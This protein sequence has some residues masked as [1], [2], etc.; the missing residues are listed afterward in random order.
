M[1]VEHCENAMRRDATGAPCGVGNRNAR[2][3]ARQRAAYPA[4]P[5]G[6]PLGVLLATDR[7]AVEGRWGRGAGRRPGTLSLPRGAGRGAARRYSS[8]S[9]RPPADGPSRPSRPPPGGAAALVARAAA[10]SA[11]YHAAPGPVALVGAARRAARRRATPRR[12]AA[13]PTRFA[14]SPRVLRAQPG[15]GRRSPRAYLGVTAAGLATPCHPRDEGLVTSH[16]P[17]AMLER[18]QGS[19][20]PLAAIGLPQ[21]IH[22]NEPSGGGGKFE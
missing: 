11:A 16:G 12:A 1:T 17:H 20:L 2:L 5:A 18:W 9:A 6:A 13:G 22:Q 14:L 10:R 4:G 3:R 8:G 7:G 21:R 19:A 15:W